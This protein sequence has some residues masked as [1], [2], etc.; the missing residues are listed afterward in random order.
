MA[1]PP[2][3]SPLPAD[4]RSALAELSKEKIKL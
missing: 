2:K 4:K 3:Q 1:F